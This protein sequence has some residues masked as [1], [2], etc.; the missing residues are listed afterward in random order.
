MGMEEGRIRIREAD[1]TFQYD[2]MLKDHLGNVRMVLTDE[3]KTDDYIAATLEPA[4]INT[5]EQYYDNLGTTQYDKPEWFSDPVY[6][7]N[8]K[9]AQVKN[10]AGIQ[11]IGPSILLKVMAGDSYNI[12]VASGWNSVS[13]ASNSTPNVLTDLFNALTTGLAGV[14]GG[15]ATSTQLAN[16][17]SGLNSGLTTFLSGQPESGSK[18]KAYISWIVFD[19]QFKIVSTAS[20]SEQ[21]GASNATTIHTK[22]GLTIPKN[23]YLYI[24]SSNEATNID[25]FFDNLQV[26]HTRGPILEET[27]YYPFGLV[28]QGISS[29]A[30][31]G[32]AE[33]KFKYNGKEEQRKE[34]A[35]GSGLDWLDYG[36][37]MY[38]N[39]IGRWHCVDPL[40]EMSRK[41]STYNY[42][43]NNPVIFID[44]DGM[45]SSD[46]RSTGEISSHEV[47][48]QTDLMSEAREDFRHW[49]R[50]GE[51]RTYNDN[52]NKEGPKAAVVSGGYN[53][54]RGGLPTSKKRG[55]D[56]TIKVT[57][58]KDSVGIQI[59]QTVRVSN[60]DN[61]SAT[62]AKTNGVWVSADGK[63]IGF[64]DPGGQLYYYSQKEIGMIKA[65][66]D[67]SFNSSTGEGQIR[68]VD[69]PDN[70]NGSPPY[71]KM[72]F[73]KYIVTV[74]GDG[75][76]QVAGRIQ[77]TYISNGGK[78]TSEPSGSPRI[79]S[80]VMNPTDKA[81]IN[82]D[83]NAKRQ[84]KLK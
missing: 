15:K 26:T 83:P 2:Y 44:P 70:I 59:I 36:A 46:F 53:V 27:H 82:A 66:G 17:G 69:A 75:S 10:T 60:D 51:T 18:P 63:E 6:S 38:D 42:A 81:I 21:V 47:E 19:E 65:K 55:F 71:K 52:K 11:K 76:Q 30:L 32:Y 34:F 50:T 23:G 61:V 29:K 68:F 56:F 43:Y 48:R 73:T 8:T 41:W 58:A 13:T 54:H 37:R 31:T 67:Y 39:Q 62:D 25:V 7:T 35:D 45:M 64:T 80:G 28:Q 22:T 1:K 77:S 72:T 57:G 74:N 33:N 3:L 4:T 78:F 84:L 49:L 24:Y 9:V 5:E 79:I 14:S 12:R 20:S 16:S 40:S